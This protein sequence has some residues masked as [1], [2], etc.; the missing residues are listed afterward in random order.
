MN[1]LRTMRIVVRRYKPWVWRRMVVRL[2]YQT[3]QA[4]FRPHDHLVDLWR[5]FTQHDMQRLDRALRADH[6]EW[7]RI[8]LQ[9]MNTEG[10]S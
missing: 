10:W 9:K 5:M 1:H 2:V 6:E 8:A 7:A 3:L 4:S